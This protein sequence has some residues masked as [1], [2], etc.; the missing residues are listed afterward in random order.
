ML[1]TV[2][3]VFLVWFVVAIAVSLGLG[4]IISVGSRSYPLPKRVTELAAERRR[5][6]RKRHSDGIPV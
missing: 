4:A 3:Q 5:T 2:A 1:S 6:L